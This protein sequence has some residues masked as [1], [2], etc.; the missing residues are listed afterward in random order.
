[1]R[2][3]AVREGW[4]FPVCVVGDER[5]PAARTNIFV[6]LVRPRAT[7][8]DA[9]LAAKKTGHVTQPAGHSG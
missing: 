9:F 6:D 8:V 2:P 4:E 1:M 3:F 7:G 5:R